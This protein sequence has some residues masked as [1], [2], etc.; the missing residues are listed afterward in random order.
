MAFSVALGILIRA[1]T[2]SRHLKELARQERIRERVRIASELHDGAGHRMLGIVMHA[3]QLSTDAPKAAHAIED[4]ALEVQREI[5]EAV[6]W[7]PRS[8]RAPTEQASLSDQV[9]A[10]GIDLP[11]VDLAVHFD[12]VEAEGNLHASTRLA[13]LRIIQ[14]GV[15]N[16]IKHGEGPIEVRVEFGEQLDVSIVSTPVSRG[17]D[18]VRC[19][20]R[21]QTAVPL[22]PGTGQGLFHMRRRAA[23]L[24]GSFDYEELP[25]GGVRITTVL[26][27]RPGRPVRATA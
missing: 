22:I 13:A 3:R 19:R 24:G 8:G 15:T 20:G 27:S 7:L 4:L 21:G 18:G 9:I 11:Q 14:E 5:R 1:R 25:G 6:G 23:E 17:D 10:L 12:N 2:R 16:A 26:P